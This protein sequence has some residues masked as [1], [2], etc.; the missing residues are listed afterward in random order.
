MRTNLNTD[1]RIRRNPE[2]HLQSVTFVI[3]LGK[4]R[5]YRI[6]NTIWHK[7]SKIT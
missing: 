3:N 6:G 4:Y 5:E 1:K 7:N 2:L